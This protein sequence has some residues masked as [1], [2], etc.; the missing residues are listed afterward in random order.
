QPGSTFKPFV[1]GAALENG[2]MP[3]DAL[4]DWA[5][6][7]VNDA[8]GQYWA[9]DNFGGSSGSLMSLRQALAYSKNTITAQ[10]VMRLG[11]DRVAD[12]ARRAGIR[13]KLD[14]VPSIGLGTSPVSLLELTAAYATFANLGRYRA[15]V[16]VTHI[17]NHDGKVIA[18]FAPP[19]HR[20]I[21]EHV[22]YGVLDMMRGVVDRGTG[23]RIRSVYGARGELAGKT[24]TTQHAA[25]GWFML[26][27]PDLVIG[28]WV[29]FDIQELTFRTSWW[30]QG[31][32]TALQT[33]GRFQN[34][35]DLPQARFERPE[36][37]RDG[38][39]LTRLLREKRR[40]DHGGGPLPWPDD[41]DWTVAG[42][43]VGWAGPPPGAP[44]FNPTA[45]LNFQERRTRRVRGSLEQLRRARN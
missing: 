14:P 10:L 17:E 30:G 36:E 1:Y 34:L 39:S 6:T 9:P 38:M 11:A 29:G 3:E 32:H 8:T 41:S 40:E 5:F 7:Y 42:L 16:T 20:A 31:S 12:F 24:G 22:A 18:Q 26:V 45:W 2:Y 35:V 25:D 21:P 23:V 13:T 4:P 37:L 33:V 27:H 19:A 28:S 44:G 15:P 43:E